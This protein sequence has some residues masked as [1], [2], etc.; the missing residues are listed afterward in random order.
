[1]CAQDPEGR[2]AVQVVD[3]ATGREAYRDS[4]G[5]LVHRWRDPGTGKVMEETHVGVAAV[6]PHVVLQLAP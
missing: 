3:A 2:D 4:E 6:T 5:R 1:M